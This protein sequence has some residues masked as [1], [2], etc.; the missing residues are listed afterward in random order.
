V[1]ATPALMEMQ[2]FKF[3][4]RRPSR[5]ALEPCGKDEIATCMLAVLKLIVEVLASEGGGSLRSSGAWGC[6]C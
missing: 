1:L 3:C 2:S 4:G 6:F 5:P